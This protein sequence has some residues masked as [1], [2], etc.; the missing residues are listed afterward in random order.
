M[1]YPRFLAYVRK[2][3]RVWFCRGVDIANHWRRV[4]PP[5]RRSLKVVCGQ[6]AWV[7]TYV[8]PIIRP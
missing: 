1:R 5:A 6:A 3:D 7:A 2:H 4:H 8:P